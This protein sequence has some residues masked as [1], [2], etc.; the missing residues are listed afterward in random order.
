[1]AS[2]KAFISAEGA[3]RAVIPIWTVTNGLVL[4]IGL[5]LTVYGVGSKTI[6]R[7]L[8]FG[9]ISGGLGAILVIL[10]VVDAFEWITPA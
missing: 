3:F 5:I 6:I 9:S 8:P 4:I 2:I 1:M 7:I 10:S